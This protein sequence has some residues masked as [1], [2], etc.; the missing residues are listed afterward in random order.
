M[1]PLPSG[2]QASPW[3]ATFSRVTLSGGPVG[4]KSADSGS[5]YTALAESDRSRINASF[6][7]LGENAGPQ[8]PNIELA[9]LVKRRFRAPSVAI[10]QIPSASSLEVRPPSAI[11]LPS[12]V[13]VRL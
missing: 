9:D 11:H 12:G 2:I 3:M 8:S 13:Q 7:P 1:R 10:N 4:V 6:R 5:T